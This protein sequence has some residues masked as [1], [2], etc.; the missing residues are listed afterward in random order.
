MNPKQFKYF[1][2]TCYILVILACY[3]PVIIYAYNMDKIDPV[4]TTKKVTTNP[5]SPTDKVLDQ[6]VETTFHDYIVVT[7]NGIVSPNGVIHKANCKCK[8]KSND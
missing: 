6:D 7:R 4:V 2:L 5:V 8:S 1:A 3:S